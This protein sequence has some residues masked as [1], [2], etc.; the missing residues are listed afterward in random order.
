[1]RLSIA[2]T[3]GNEEF[4]RTESAGAEVEKISPESTKTNK[5]PNRGDFWVLAGSQKARLRESSFDD[6]PIDADLGVRRLDPLPLT[7]F[8]DPGM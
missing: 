7:H 3:I 8:A 6:A 5:V 2:K 4:E 1:V